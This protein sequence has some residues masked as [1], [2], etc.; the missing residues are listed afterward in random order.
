MRK[1]DDFKDELEN[2]GVGDGIT[3]DQAVGAVKRNKTWL[4]VAGVVAVVILLI[5]I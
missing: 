1:I 2:V 4:I 5:L 3:K